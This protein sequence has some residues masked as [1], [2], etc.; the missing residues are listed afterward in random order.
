M[1]LAWLALAVGPV[2]AQDGLVG[3]NEFQVNAFETGDQRIPSL[4]LADGDG[5][6]VLW[7]SINQVAPGWGLYARRVGLLGDIQG[8]EQTINAFNVG[9]QESPRA[10]RLADGRL[11]AVWL[12]PD[13]RPSAELI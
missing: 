3:L 6:L 5:L 12:G 11:A 2:Q 7:Q 4:V 8:D 9:N 10:A 13:E 1:L